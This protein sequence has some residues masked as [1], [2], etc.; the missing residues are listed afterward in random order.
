MT[1]TNGLHANSAGDNVHT[2]FA[3]VYADSTARLAA[4]G[5]VAGDVNKLA[6][7]LSDATAWLL[8]DDSPITWAQI[9]GSNYTDEQAQDAIGAMIADTNTID[10]TY[11][12]ATPEL[13]ADVKQQMSITSD[14]SGLKLSGDA[15]SPGNNKVYGTS[16]S[17][18][19]GWKDDPTGGAG[20]TVQ[21][22]ALK[23]ATPTYDFDGAALDGA[24]SAHSGT[25]SFATTDCLTQS[26]LVWPGSAIS[27][28]ESGQRGGL[29]VA[30][31]DSDLDF[32]VGGLSRSGFGASADHMIGI[33]ALDSAGTGIGIAAYNDG[34][35]YFAKIIT[36][37]YNTNSDSWGG[38]GNNLT[39]HKGILNPLWMRL[40]RVSGTWTAYASVS[41]KAWDK[42][43][44]TRADA[45]TVDKL[46][47]GELY[48]SGTLYGILIA[49]YFHVDV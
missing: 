32:Q 43:F 30:H 16:G 33:A 42:T 46:Y 18:T 6:L 8:T 14:A 1:V 3:F 44:T 19:K 48:P 5:F 11:T 36:W 12:D 9:G 10:M 34:V 7:Q 45:I 15:A 49:D 41:G 29:Y 17:G 27:M 22:P 37:G 2:P 47:F 38:Y 13:K 31:A 21:Y 35:V 23:P 26:P 20:I 25:G 40:K 4:T 39:G 24:F 28:H